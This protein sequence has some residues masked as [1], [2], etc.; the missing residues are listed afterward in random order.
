MK[1]RIERDV[2]ADVVTWVSRTLPS[3]V[4]FPALAGVLVDAG[5]DGV[6]FVE[7]EQDIAMHGGVATLSAWA[8]RDTSDAR[9]CG[10]GCRFVGG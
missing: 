3:R 6:A 10:L 4:P 2:L 1:F 8:N 9:G 5:D 7:P